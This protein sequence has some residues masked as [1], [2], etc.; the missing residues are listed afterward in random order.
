LGIFSPILPGFLNIAHAQW[1]WAAN[2]MDF[3]IGNLFEWSM[4]LGRVL[5]SYLASFSGGLLDLSIE[6]FVLN[7][8][9]KVDQI[10]AIDGLWQTFRDL[11]NIAFIGIL[12]YIAI[13]TILNIGNKFSTKELL[14]RLVIVA[15]FVNFS[16]FATKVVIDTSNVVALQF[17]NAVQVED[18]GEDECNLSHFF[19]DALNLSSVNSPAAIEAKANASGKLSIALVMGII[20][21]LTTA[22]V[23][24]AMALLLIIRF[25]VLVL[26]MIASPLAFI[27][28]A[29][30]GGSNWGQ[31]W[32]DKLL[33]QSFFAPA[34]LAMVYLTARMAKGL[35]SGIAGD[36]ENATDLTAIVASTNTAEQFGALIVFIIIIAL[37]LASVIVA[38]KI[39]AAGAET[40]VKWGK[41]ARNWGQA[42]IVGGAKAVA[43][44]PVKGAGAVA[45][46][47][48][49]RIGKLADDKFKKTHF[50]EGYLGKKIRSNTTEK[51]KKASFGLKQGYDDVRKEREAGGERQKDW[52]N[53]KRVAG[54]LNNSDASDKVR[55]DALNSLTRSQQLEMFK[56]NKEALKDNAHLLDSDTLR[57]FEKR[58]HSEKDDDKDFKEEDLQEFKEVISDNLE[59]V[60]QTGNIQKI[61]EFLGKLSN[62]QLQQLRLK[63]VQNQNVIENMSEKQLEQ[64]K[65]GRTKNEQDS[66]DDA[67]LQQ[68]GDAM[69][70]STN[71]GQA[72]K[73]YFGNM[74]NENVS[75]QIKRYIKRI[76]I[77]QITSSDAVMDQIDNKIMAHLMNNLKSGEQEKIYR[78]L[79]D[80]RGVPAD[81]A[82]RIPTNKKHQAATQY[83]SGV[84]I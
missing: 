25:V 32:V 62:D 56:T 82:D 1:G 35:Q 36:G 46:E 14:V 34:M 38:K 29:L 77:S 68:M 12:L 75:K 22:F 6:Y 71:P 23:M 33:S 24:G 18:C 42:K 49:G 58:A 73:D 69:Y 57:E 47:G 74:S 21:M 59:G 67:R 52:K 65:K 16:L 72:V 20:F 17:Y 27:A 60:A 79:I 19:A 41:N 78:D 11:G 64:A 9:E 63:S 84:R 15:L 81:P 45:R 28:F 54:V 40:T 83:E 55:K 44:A 26:L 10:S 2:F 4:N 51:A 3:T 70:S 43:M 50:A 7:M 37:M 53:R 8:A 5:S 66:I 31:K 61:K 76:N 13:R 39:G 48:V 80:N 30:P